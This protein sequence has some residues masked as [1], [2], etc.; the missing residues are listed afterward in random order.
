MEIRKH[1]AFRRDAAPE[2]FCF[3]KENLIPFEE[4]GMIC[5]VDILES[6][7][8]WECIS[9]YIKEKDLFCSS[10]TV[11]TTDEMNNSEWL[12]VRSQWR[13][14]YPQPESA[15]Q[16]ETITYTRDNH[17][18]KCGCG[19]NQVDAFRFKQLPKWGKRHFL[20]LNWIED[21]LFVSDAAK[22]V[23]QQ[24]SGMEFAEVQ[25]KTGMQSL[26]GVSQILIPTVLPKGL[27]E[28]NSPIR[29]KQICE[30]CGAVKYT[31]T[32]IGMLTFKKNIF[33]GA[34]DV[35]KSYEVF[36]DR[37]LAFRMLFVRQAVY[38]AILANKLD[39]NLVFEP[40]NLIE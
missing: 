12:R 19:L 7:P 26:P 16:F 33:S 40:L 35:V 11:F 20:M 24:F 4:G 36:G 15:F 6:S 37:R 21:E 29:N 2:L 28:D 31:T 18:S 3:L 25:N 8:Y 39:K 13:F 23:L 5:S 38:Q 17:C 32:G 10:E 14:G 27:V 34:P 22:S 1:I 9:G 30:H